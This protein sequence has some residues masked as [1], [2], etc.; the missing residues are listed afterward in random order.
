MQPHVFPGGI[1]NLRANV[2]SGIAPSQPYSQSNGGAFWDSKNNGAAT[3]NVTRQFVDSSRTTGAIPMNPP[4]FSGI[5]A[6]EMRARPGS[7]FPNEVAQ[8]NVYGE[9]SGAPNISRFFSTGN[10]PSKQLGAWKGYPN[11]EN[12][13]I[14]DDQGT[15]GTGVGSTNQRTL[16]EAV[17]NPRAYGA[18]YGEIQSMQ[19]L[20]PL[21]S[22][23]FASVKNTV[24]PNAQLEVVYPVSE[25]NRML[26]KK[27]EDTLR[28]LHD[29]KEVP[30]KELVDTCN[31]F[32]KEWSFVG[33][34]IEV[35]ET[36]K[37]FVRRTVRAVTVRRGPAMV[38][39][40][41]G[42]SGKRF[43]CGLR[44]FIM[45]VRFTFNEQSGVQNDFTR[46]E[47]AMTS[48]STITHETM[49]ID[50]GRATSLPF[51]D[52]VDRNASGIGPRQWPE[53]GRTY[54][55]MVPFASVA[56]TPPPARLW[57]GPDWQGHY[58]E[59][60][61]VQ[62][63]DSVKEYQ[64]RLEN[65]VREVLHPRPGDYGSSYE[66]FLKLPYLEIHVGNTQ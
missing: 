37:A 58:W 26:R 1:H 49:L 45:F 46:Q 40:I 56:D 59:V 52:Y 22:F 28:R 36:R 10:V 64:K 24:G 13:G 39:N 43:H 4:N 29:F 38:R 66:S 41:F 9:M 14:T 5:R 63:D 33:V 48:L 65:R 3:S 44:L 35:N 27:A 2:E 32:A 15:T 6:N 60:G 18:Q 20:V 17:L 55:Q 31:G 54:W 47:D 12:I 62:Q 57:N 11:S 34:P 8:M 21:N 7:S 30:I 42:T 25:I 23:C 53:P 61:R 50:D 16:W 51:Y 19:T